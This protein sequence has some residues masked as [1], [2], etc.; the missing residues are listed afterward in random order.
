MVAPNAGKVAL[1]ATTLW[2]PLIWVCWR[3]NNGVWHSQVCGHCLND[4]LTTPDGL[5][6]HTT[7]SLSF[8]WAIWLLFS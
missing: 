8:D 4:A 3:S 5:S 6:I 1:G 7:P 2:N